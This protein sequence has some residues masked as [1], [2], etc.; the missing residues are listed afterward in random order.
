[1]KDR[2]FDI[3]LSL[4][5]GV[6]NREF[7]PIL[8]LYESSFQLF[9]AIE[10]ELERLPCSQRL[11]AAL[12]D[13]TLDEAYR[14]K[15]YCEE[16]GVEILFW[17]DR[18][19]PICLRGLMDPPILLYIRGRIP[20]FDEELSIGVV[21]TRTMSE[22]GKRMAYKIGYELASGNILVVSGMALGVDG[23]ATAAALAAGGHPVAVLGS[24]VDIAYPSGHLTLYEHLLK[25]G[26]VISEYPPGTAPE[27][28]HFP[29]RNR[30]ISGLTAGTVVVEADEKSG[31]MITARTALMQ[32]R[33]IFAVPGNVGEHTAAGTNR[34][35]REGAQM[36]T[37]GRS[38]AEYYEPEYRGQI[39]MVRLSLAEKRSDPND[40]ALAYYRVQMRTISSHTPAPKKHTSGS[41]R[42]PEDDARTQ[43]E[44]PHPR[45]T[46]RHEQSRKEATPP[47]QQL[48]RPSE[49]RTPVT[50]SD[51]SGKVLESLTE[52]QRAVFLAMPLEHAVPL[53]AIIKE[54]FSMGDALAAMTVL[55]IKGLIASLPGGLYARR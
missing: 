33:D 36:V 14:I 28:Q 11:R 50:D 15:R 35:I 18:N 52:T 40:A 16:Y 25:K 55:E 7:I 45:M 5:V 53:D 41:L 2:L 12:A 23:V 31:A 24:G 32:G 19:Y 37:S 54:G 8:E 48:P 20:D 27:G 1:M 10:E 51:R 38:I 3:W 49:G 21:G 39:D 6:A 9:H 26:T 22:Y 30:L 42:T 43:T 4:R 46:E 47:P 13:K 44:A 17:K 29:V 34:L